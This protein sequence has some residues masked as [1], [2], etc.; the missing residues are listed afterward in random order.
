MKKEDEFPEHVDSMKSVTTTMT[1]G[2]DDNA[3]SFL[4]ADLFA[5]VTNDEKNN[6][7]GSPQEDSSN[8]EAKALQSF[9]DDKDTMSVQTFD[10]D[11][12]KNSRIIE[13]RDFHDIADKINSTFGSIRNDSWLVLRKKL[14]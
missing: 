12:E 4:L 6:D 14:A 11:D 13:K 2:Q 3:S 5:N 8:F 9:F 10:Y 7:S 1:I